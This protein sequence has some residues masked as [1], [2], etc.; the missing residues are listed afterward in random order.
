MSGQCSTREEA[1]KHIFYCF[2]GIFGNL[3]HFIHSNMFDTVLYYLCSVQNTRF[4]PLSSFF[5][6][7]FDIDF[8]MRSM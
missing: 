5:S 3:F 2:I 6:K 4:T 1:F 7:I 8:E